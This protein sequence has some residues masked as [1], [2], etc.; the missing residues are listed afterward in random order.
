MPKLLRPLPRGVFAHLLERADEREIT[1][2][3]LG[4]LARWVDRDPEVPPGRWFKRFPGLIVCGDGEMVTTF[5]RIG[6][7][8]DGE[9]VV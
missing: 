9:E 3:Q 1:A 4:L 6:Q 7:V 5:L 8:P 2:A